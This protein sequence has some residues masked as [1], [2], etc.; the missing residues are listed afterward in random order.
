M[1]KIYRWADRPQHSLPPLQLEKPQR[2]TVA[3]LLERI[4]QLEARIAELEGKS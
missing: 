1:G 3:E 2:E 4:E